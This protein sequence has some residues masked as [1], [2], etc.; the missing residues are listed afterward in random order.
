M[1]RSM[2]E[3]K[4]VNRALASDLKRGGSVSRA[5]GRDIDLLQ[6]S[7]PKIYFLPSDVTREFGFLYRVS[8]RGQA[9][10]TR[11]AQVFSRFLRVASKACRLEVFCRISAR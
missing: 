8:I 2:P 3:A 10:P 7:R 5:H 4:Q 6:M 1:G 11:L 9:G